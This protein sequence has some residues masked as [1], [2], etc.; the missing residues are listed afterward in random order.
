MDQTGTEAAEAVYFGGPLGVLLLLFGVA[1][2][3]GR[4]LGVQRGFFRALIAASVGYLSGLAIVHIQFGDASSFSSIPD[5]LEL[6]L[7]FLSWILLVTMTTSIVLE[8]VLRPRAQ[9]KPRHWSSP[10]RW[11][12]HQISALHRL[13]TVARA[14]R[15]NGLVRGGLFGPRAVSCPEGDRA[16]DC[17]ARAR[18]LRLT[19]EECGGMFIKFGQLAAGRTDLL[20][21]SMTEEL[22]H[23]RGAVKPLPWEDVDLLLRQE[24]G[25]EYLEQFE[26]FEHTAF[27]AASIGVIHRARL[28]NGRRVIVKV[29]RPGIEDLVERDRRALLWAARQLERASDQARQLRL[30]ELAAELVDSVVDELDFTREAANNAAMRRNERSDGHVRFPEVHQDLTTRR[31]LIMDEVLGSPVSDAWAVDASGVDREVLADRLLQSYLDQ[32]L[33]D[34]I[35]HADPHPGN[36]LIT[37]PGS[38]AGT[39]NADVDAGGTLWLVDFGAVGF[40]DPIMLEALQQ[41]AAGF[42]LRDA[43]ILARAVRRLV[44]EES[45]VD[46]KSLEYDMA[47]VLTSADVG[48]FGPAALAEVIQVVQRHQ[49]KVPTAMTLLGRAAVTMAGTLRQLSSGYDMAAAAGRLV[50]TDPSP[51]DAKSL[52]TREVMR[53]LPALRSLPQLGEDLALQARS[54]RL[55]IQVERFAGADRDRV[56]NWIDQILW[57]G[58]SMAGLLAAVLLLLASGLT[59]DEGIHFYTKAIG[60]LGLMGA[61]LM[62]MRTVARILQRRG[63]REN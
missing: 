32:V 47:R 54:G 41:F 5:G 37:V 38:D 24:L 13:W 6:G 12:R 45:E 1:W 42:A 51:K 31:V 23:L 18:A 30:A 35:Y 21:D 19:L 60:Y 61:S 57:A 33:R 14:A 10:L 22:N 15:H 49:V 27:A 63:T 53:A 50:N 7:G 44:G 11:V 3:S 16:L 17:P 59:Q 8:A 40:L 56:Q 9:G 25:D 62:Q 2:L 34:G 52:L 28:S 48:G 46:I 58:I 55:G 4:I 43:A 36:V 26:F 20:P 39:G 29:Q